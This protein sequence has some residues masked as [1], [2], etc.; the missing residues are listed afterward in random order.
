MK[1]RKVRDEVMLLHLTKKFKSGP[2]KSVKD[3]SRQK[4]RQE[5]QKTITEELKFLD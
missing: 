3:Y 2:H 5:T 4:A 1:K